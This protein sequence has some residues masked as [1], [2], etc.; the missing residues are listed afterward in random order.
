MPR[1]SG[2]AAP[3]ARRAED[4][5]LDWFLCL[6]AEMPSSEVQAQFEA[7]HAHPDC[8]AAYA[9]LVTLWG[10]P[11]FAAALERRAIAIPAPTRKP[12]FRRLAGLAAAAAVLFALGAIYLPEL[13]MRLAADY[14]TA[15][16][17]RREIVLPD[18]SRMML[19]AAS[20]VALDFSDG[21]RSVRLLAG[22]A[23]FDVVHDTQR[24]FRVEGHFS[25]VRVTG[26]AFA[27]R[28]GSHAD[29]V[30]LTR[31]GVDV[32]P[33]SGTDAAA[34]LVPGEM[35][36]IGRNGVSAVRKVDPSRALAWMDGRL[37]FSNRQ[38]GAVLDDIRRYYAGTIVMLSSGLADEEVSGSY[39]LDNP[40]LVLRSLA[41][42]TG[43]HMDVLPGG[44]IV[45]R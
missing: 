9:K 28:A 26:T 8:A 36:S 43:A 18:G 19:D 23:F 41:E 40:V 30:V 34:H 32:T 14:I 17:E 38:L 6:Q 37:S 11:A 3:D 27:V 15:T 21:R 4:D 29:E 16:A 12:L 20:A 44:L 45:L 2:H 10:D 22:D 13:R 33:L 1:H 39:R 5:A 42:A 35:V 24:P 25:V 31:G 7:W